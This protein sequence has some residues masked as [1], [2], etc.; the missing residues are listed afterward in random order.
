MKASIGYKMTSFEVLA[1][2]K[3]ELARLEWALEQHRKRPRTEVLPSRR[4]GLVHLE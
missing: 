3:W 1:G 4:L 2:H